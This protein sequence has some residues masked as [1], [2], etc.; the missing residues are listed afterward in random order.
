[1]LLEHR[2]I[3]NTVGT[4][5]YPVYRL[6]PDEYSRYRKHLLALDADSRYTRF[7]HM[8][9]DEVIEQLCDRFEAN[10]KEHKIFV[11]ENE[12]LEVVAAG[13]ISLEGG[14][15]ELAF[16]VLKEYRKQGM[17]DALMKRTIEW[18][19]NRN[20]KGG[21]MVCLSTNVAIKR[22]ASKHGVLINE[23]GETLANIGIPEATPTSVM[24]EVVESNMARLDHISKVQKNFVRSLYKV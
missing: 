6:R 9:K 3:S 2:S 17:G 21:C 19:Q 10:P 15:T 22:L 14:E 4:D 12:V 24:H 8:I 11:I 23:G 1:V 7:G 16:S 5:M 18:C 13:H 20:I